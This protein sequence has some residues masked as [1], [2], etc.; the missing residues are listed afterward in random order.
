MCIQW[1]CKK[2]QDKLTILTHHWARERC[3]DFYIA[4]SED[5]TITECPRGPWVLQRASHR[6]PYKGV[7]RCDDCI[8][9]GRK[10]S[11]RVQQARQRTNINYGELREYSGAL[12]VGELVIPDDFQNTS[13]P[14]VGG[15]PDVTKSDWEGFAL[16]NRHLPSHELEREPA[17]GFAPFNVGLGSQSM[18]NAS[19]VRQH[20]KGES[21]SPRTAL[22]ETTYRSP[23]EPVQHPPMHNTYKGEPAVGWE[24]PK[25]I[26]PCTNPTPTNPNSRTLAAGTSQGSLQENIHSNNYTTNYIPNATVQE[27]ASEA[28]HRGAEH[29]LLH[30]PLRASIKTQHQ[31]SPPS[32]VSSS[33]PTRARP[34]DL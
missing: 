3:N 1:C 26:Y 20:V 34:W 11:K 22:A 13:Q 16:A 30:L 19:S 8:K 17:A 14:L 5:P 7:Q 10:E 32:H 29:Q 2:C 12:Y 23:Y 6:N 18:G 25:S 9:A 4:R 28:T 31:P 27:Q 24:E 21:P 15:Q 33:R